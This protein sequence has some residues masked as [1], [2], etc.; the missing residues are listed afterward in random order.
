MLRV[1]DQ[2]SLGCA[3]YSPARGLFAV[4][5]GFADILE[6]SVD[7]L[8]GIGPRDVTHPDEVIA[9]EWLL[10]GALRTGSSFAFRKRYRLP[11]RTDRWVQ[12]R[13]TIIRSG[14]ESIALLQSRRVIPPTGPQHLI[15]DMTG[16]VPCYVQQMSAELARMAGASGMPVTAELLT[17]VARMAADEM[18]DRVTA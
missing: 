14:E 17:M 2:L 5:Q 11:D 3:L 4:D 7:D 16:S 1:L 15:S 9:N 13:Y 18:T 6:R 10:E 8:I 12:N